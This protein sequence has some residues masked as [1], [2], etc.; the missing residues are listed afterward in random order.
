MKIGHDGWP[1]VIVILVI[2]GIVILYDTWALHHDKRTI[3]QLMQR[4]GR[5]WWWFKVLGFAA[6]AFLAWHLFQGFPWSLS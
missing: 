4:F 3:S 6:F 2:L 1:A 5:L